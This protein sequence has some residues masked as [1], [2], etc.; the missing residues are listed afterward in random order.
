MR[1]WDGMFWLGVAVVFW[2]GVMCC[3]SFVWV[4]D[5]ATGWVNRRFESC[6]GGW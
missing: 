6:F 4:Y 2:L 5:K 3:F 1:N